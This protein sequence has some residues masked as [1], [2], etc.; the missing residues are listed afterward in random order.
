MHVK[1]IFQQWVTLNSQSCSQRAEAQ[2]GPLCAPRPVVFH[3]AGN[4]WAVLGCPS[5]GGELS[6]SAGWRPDTLERKVLVQNETENLIDINTH[7]S[8]LLSV[9][10]L[11]TGTVSN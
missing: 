11:F 9:K 4:V 6:A 1:F 10:I 5:W 7:K 2:A 8:D 3:C